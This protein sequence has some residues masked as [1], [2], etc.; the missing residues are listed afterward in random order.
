MQFEQWIGRMRQ[1]AAE[2]PGTGACTL[3]SAM[4]LWLWTVRY[5]Q[6]ARDADGKPLFRDRRQGVTF[7]MADALCWLLASRQQILDVAELE[8][9]GPAHPSLAE[10]LPGYVRFFTDLCHVQTARAGGEVGRICAELVFGYNRHPSWD[11]SCGGCV[12]ANEVDALEGVIPGI[13]VGAR[14]TGDVLE[15]DGSHMDKAGPCVRFAGVYEFMRRRSRLDACLTGNRLAKDRAAQA[16]T[17]V[18][19]A[20]QLDYPR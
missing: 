1:V 9:E 12:P 10:T 16:L 11:E 8:S 14:I 15:T 5:L 19:V 18:P 4:E 7:P 20:D 3:A 13:S 17:Q 6:E 2:R